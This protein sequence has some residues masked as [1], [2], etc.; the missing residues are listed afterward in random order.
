MIMQ[1][2][3]PKKTT[4]TK[5][6]QKKKKKKKKTTTKNKTKRLCPTFSSDVIMPLSLFPTVECP[7][8]TID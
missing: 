6:K 5:T 1:K 3:K 7:L 4:T 2:K 8:H